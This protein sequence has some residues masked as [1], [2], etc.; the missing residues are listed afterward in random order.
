MKEI[1]VGIKNALARNERGALVTIVRTM[2]STP[3]K[4]GARMLFLANGETIGTIGGGCVE[5]GLW[6][7][8]EEVIRTG[9]PKRLS[10]R[11][12]AEGSDSCGGDAGVA[13]L[14]VEPIARKD[15]KELSASR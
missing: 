8:A 5:A 2:G 14:F 3:R 10:Y 6:R 12:T 7:E 1:F 9:R 11:L 15:N 4:P 13:E